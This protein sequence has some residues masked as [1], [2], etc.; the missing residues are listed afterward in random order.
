M[1]HA[2]VVVVVSRV[3]STY[4]YMLANC[5]VWNYTA[6]E[7]HAANNLETRIFVFSHFN[8]VCVHIKFTSNIAACYDNDVNDVTASHV[9]SCC[10]SA[11]ILRV[12]STLWRM[13]NISE[14]FFLNVW[15]SALSEPQYFLGNVY[16]SQKKITSTWTLL[17]RNP[18]TNVDNLD[19]HEVKWRHWR[20]AGGILKLYEQM[21]SSNAENLTILIPILFVDRAG[22]FTAA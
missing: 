3:T 11:A 2:A 22:T 9:Y 20:H 17:L 14:F 15:F 4:M 10:V 8:P 7:M 12:V 21:L 5:C 13:A 18:R 6:V 19:I 1:L 16:I